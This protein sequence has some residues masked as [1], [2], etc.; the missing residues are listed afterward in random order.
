MFYSSIPLLLIGS[1]IA[2]PLDSTGMLGTR[3]SA[4]CPTTHI[5]AARASTEQ[6]GPGIIGSLATLVQQAN[7]G[8]DLASV[9]YPATLD[10]YAS[11]SSMGTA[12]LTQMLTNFTSQCPQSKV[13]LLGYSQ[14]AQVVGDT[15]CGGGG[16]PGLGAAT[17]PIDAAIS[18]KGMQY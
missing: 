2:A 11:S 13:V 16:A 5:I 10:N 9:D 6:P 1:A 18:D 7:T 3:Q 17:P 14:G 4:T 12:A 8:T 15:L